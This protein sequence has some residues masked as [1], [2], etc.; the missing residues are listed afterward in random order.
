ML[1]RST[2]T[3]ARKSAHGQTRTAE[4]PIGSKC[5]PD[6]KRPSQ[7]QAHCTV[8]HVTFGGVS[9]FDRHHGD[10]DCLSPTDLGMVERDGVWRTPMSD[11]ARASFVA[12]R[13]QGD[14]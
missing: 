3:T 10:R 4:R 13:D 7:T 11:A 14:A 1:N 6:C 2:R 12:K 5:G 8:C 9:G